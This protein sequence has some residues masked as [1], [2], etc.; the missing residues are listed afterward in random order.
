MTAAPG[1]S[2]V[3][4][5][6]AAAVDIIHSK[7]AGAHNLPCEAWPHKPRVQ[8]W[9]GL[10]AARHSGTRDLFEAARSEEVCYSSV[11]QV[12]THGYEGALACRIMIRVPM[13]FR[14]SRWFHSF[15]IMSP[16]RREDG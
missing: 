16:A 10:K 3:A 8:Q 14:A 13:V 6:C 5:V 4:D 9:S 7:H 2:W 1:P 11:E 12:S 15:L